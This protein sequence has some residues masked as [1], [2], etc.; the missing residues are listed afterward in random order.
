MGRAFDDDVFFIGAG[1]HFVVDLVVAQKIMAAH[2][3]DQNRHG[4]F[5]QVTGRRVVVG[6]IV[7]IV[8]R[9]L[10]A[11]CPRAEKRSDCQEF[12]PVVK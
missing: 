2:A 1:R 12:R 6:A 11:N 10:G 3:E 4:D 8:Q 5:V 7:D 9:M